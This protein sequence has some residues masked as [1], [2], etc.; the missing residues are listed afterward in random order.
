MPPHP[1]SEREWQ[2]EE[3]GR[4]VGP[5]YL[6]KKQHAIEPPKKR[7]GHPTP[8]HG[9]LFPP[10]YFS[11]GLADSPRS[12]QEREGGSQIRQVVVIMDAWISDSG[13]TLR[14]LSFLPK[15]PTAAMHQ[16][17]AAVKKIREHWG[18]IIPTGG[19]PT[20]PL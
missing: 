12:S 8:V 15:G 2:T 7:R 17:L 19:D 1:G 18:E 9:L 20:P 4:V 10:S 5:H 3:T 6:K 14:G 13:L 11:F 16:R